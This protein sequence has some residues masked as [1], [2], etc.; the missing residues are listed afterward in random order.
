MVLEIIDGERCVVVSRKVI[1][2]CE[3]FCGFLPIDYVS[4]AVGKIWMCSSGNCD[5]FPRFVWVELLMESSRSVTG[6]RPSK[7]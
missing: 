6:V 4:D 7:I 1:A 5:K 3:I 2:C